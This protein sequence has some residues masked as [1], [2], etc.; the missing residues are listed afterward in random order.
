MIE[1]L[2]V[3]LFALVLDRLV[4]EVQGIRSFR[5]YTKWLDRVVARLAGAERNRGI[6]GVILAVAPIGAGVLLAQVLLDYF[7]WP[8]SLVFGVMVLYLCLGLNRLGEEAAGVRRALEDGDL[9]TARTR[10]VAFSGRDW[11]GEA[12][13]PAIA[14]AAVETVLQKGNSQ[15]IATLF[16]YAV[17]GPFGAVVQRLAGIVDQKWGGH[18]RSG[19][20]FG[21]AAANLN[22][23]VDWV[24]AR[25][26]ALS[27]A[28]MG[29]FE[30][31]VHCWRHQSRVLSRTHK[32][33]LL[34]SGLGAMHMQVC[35]AGVDES[36]DD[37]DLAVESV[38][39]DAGDIQRAVALVWRVL[40]FWLL[41][42]VLMAMAN[43]FGFIQGGFFSSHPS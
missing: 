21:W 7:L 16:W 14:H 41:L 20:E 24:P 18:P 5:W 27:Y 3:I 12:G 8:L 22:Y 15:V 43:L 32:S 29:S 40:L 36:V 10:L 2:I 4:P 9:D 39:P 30:D 13:E 11:E 1:N 28:M 35:R 38:I 6:N 25:I 33:P 23:L 34:A 31:A 42:Y 17:F 37:E 26:T 19:S